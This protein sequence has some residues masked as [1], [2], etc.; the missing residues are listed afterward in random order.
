[1]TAKLKEIIG[2][3]TKPYGLFFDGHEHKVRSFELSDRYVDGTW[4]PYGYRTY[5]Q[6]WLGMWVEDKNRATFSTER[7][8]EHYK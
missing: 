8:E 3:L 6:N 2:N 5:S 4:F 7:L 1:M